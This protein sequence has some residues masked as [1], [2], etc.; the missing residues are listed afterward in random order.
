MS[1]NSTTP[2][3]NTPHRRTRARTGASGK[4]STGFRL[5][6]P[7]PAPLALLLLALLSLSACADDPVDQRLFFGR[8]PEIASLKH[9]VRASRILLLFGKS[10]LGKTSLLQAGLFPAIREHAIFSLSQQG[11][12]RAFPALRKVALESRHPQ[13]REQAFF[14]LAQHDDPRVIDLL[15][16]VL[17][18]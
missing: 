7:G 5:W 17:L 12:D 16:E 11:I 10:G 13:L 3:V 6:Q 15:E 1:P 14:W 8:G 18:R 9:R 2:I 4:A